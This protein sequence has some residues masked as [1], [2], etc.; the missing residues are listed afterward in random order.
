MGF[1]R[2]NNELYKFSL[3][4]S[5]LFD[6]RGKSLKNRDHFFW[7]CGY[8]KTFWENLSNTFNRNG[9]NII[10]DFEKISLGKPDLA[11]YKTPINHTLRMAKYFIF[12]CKCQSEKP[13][14]NHYKNYIK[15]ILKLDSLV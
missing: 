10:L 5:T 11:I 6:S 3:A 4:H 14:F 12:S 1:V 15:T 2:T 9:F 8:T 13:I 7:E